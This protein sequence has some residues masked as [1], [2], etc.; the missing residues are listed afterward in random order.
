MHRITPLL[1]SQGV[2]QSG[3]TT[4]AVFPSLFVKTAVFGYSCQVRP[5]H[6]WKKTAEYSIEQEQG[7]DGVR[8]LGACQTNG[9][10]ITQLEWKRPMRVAIE[11]D[12]AGERKA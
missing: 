12:L 7:K 3:Q 4:K 1:T 6:S 8:L 10:V 5:L 2:G 9:P 11:P